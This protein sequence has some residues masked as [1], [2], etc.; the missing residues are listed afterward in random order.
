MRR[1]V[2]SF[3]VLLFATM[4]AE[5]SP[6]MCYTIARKI[7]AKLR[8]LSAR[9]M[10]PGSPGLSISAASDGGA[11]KLDFGAP[12]TAATLAQFPFSDQDR[13]GLRDAVVR[14]ARA[15]GDKGLVLIDAVSGAAHCHTP[16]LFSLASGEKKAV[17]VRKPRDPLEWCGRKS[18][19]LADADG[20]AYFLETDQ[21]AG[22]VENFSITPQELDGLGMTCAISVRYKMDFTPAESFCA[23]PELCRLGP[24]AAVWARAW[25]TGSAELRDPAFS[26]VAAPTSIGADL[27]LFGGVSRLAPE[28]LGFDA[29]QNFFTILG[30][31]EADLLRI[32]AA[33]PG[34]ANGAD[35]KILTLVALY[36]AGQPVAGFVVALRRKAM[37]SLSVD[38]VQ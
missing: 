6:V 21:S 8:V 33:R 30:E 22:E 13:A 7:S 32:G 24:K 34:P 35:G 12:A 26:P 10:E 3:F 17:A 27:P 5:A 15:G 29:E 31:P 14:V 18:M 19:A 2:T 36:K 11:A 23:K 9:P 20:D 28:A 4:A 1:I 16:W 38:V 37:D 25:R